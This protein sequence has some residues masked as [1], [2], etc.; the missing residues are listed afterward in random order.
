MNLSEYPPGRLVFQ[1]DEATRWRKS[2]QSPGFCKVHKT[3]F[4]VGF[5]L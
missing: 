1:K 2:K 3:G 4:F 5:T